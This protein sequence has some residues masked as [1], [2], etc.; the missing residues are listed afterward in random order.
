MVEE[1][2]E[3]K[4]P[5]IDPKTKK[6]IVEEEKVEEELPP[7]KN[8]GHTFDI[9]NFLYDIEDTEEINELYKNKDNKE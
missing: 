2:K 4:K 1:K 6:P 3:V 5:K 7:E 9:I 8:Y